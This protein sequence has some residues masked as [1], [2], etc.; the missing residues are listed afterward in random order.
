MV[1][2]SISF[3]NHQIVIRTY[4]KKANMERCWNNTV[5]YS[6]SSLDE[7]GSFN[8]RAE[9]ELSIYML[10]SFFAQNFYF[11]GFT[12]IKPFIFKR[13]RFLPQKTPKIEWKKKFQYL[14]KGKK[15][16]NEWWKTPIWTIFELKNNFRADRKKVTSQAE[17]KIL[18]LDSDSSLAY[19]RLSALDYD[20]PVQQD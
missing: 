10:N 6:R 18:Q 12:Q 8:F 4:V 2:Q 13:K 14:C 5:L 16:K 15:R 20:Y 9:T 7:P 11:L 1:K 3:W 17:L 19:T